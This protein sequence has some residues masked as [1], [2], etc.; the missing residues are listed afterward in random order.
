MK[1]PSSMKTCIYNSHHIILL[2]IR[3]FI[4]S[5]SIYLFCKQPSCLDDD[6]TEPF[7]IFLTKFNKFYNSGI[8]STQKFFG[9]FLIYSSVKY[10]KC[11]YLI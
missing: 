2:I 4:Y 1:R 7:D 9:F 8:S 11:S 3:N 6:F 5:I 10:F